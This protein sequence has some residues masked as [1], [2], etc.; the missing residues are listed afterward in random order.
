M[1][2]RTCL[3]G[4]IVATATLAGP[5]AIMA[6][7][8]GGTTAGATTEATVTATTASIDDVEKTSPG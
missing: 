3:N 2:W 4:G 1:R 8:A 7:H 5:G 6:G